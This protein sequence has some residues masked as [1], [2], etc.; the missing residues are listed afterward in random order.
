MDATFISCHISAD[1][2]D[3]MYNS[4]EFQKN[5]SH[6]KL[7]EHSCVSVCTSGLLIGVIVFLRGIM[8]LVAPS[9]LRLRNMRLVLEW[10]QMANKLIV[11]LAWNSVTLQW[12][13]PAILDN[14]GGALKNVTWYEGLFFKAWPYSVCAVSHCWPSSNTA[15][16]GLFQS[17]NTNFCNQTSDIVVMIFFLFYPK[18]FRFKSHYISHWLSKLIRN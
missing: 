15:A 2:L 14:Q 18:K 1:A 17:T 6:F 9:A 8:F 11:W 10:M 12:H 7:C 3:T 4:C 5:C 13:C 16:W